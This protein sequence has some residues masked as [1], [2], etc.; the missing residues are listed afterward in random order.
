M[1][2]P[3][4]LTILPSGIKADTAYEPWQQCSAEHWLRDCVETLRTGT[5]LIGTSALI[6]RT[7]ERWENPPSDGL[8]D[9]LE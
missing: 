7:Y 5:L 4:I 9:E 8:L 3:R 6:F 2:I 1:K